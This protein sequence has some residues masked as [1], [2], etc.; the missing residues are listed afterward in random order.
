[1]QIRFLGYSDWRL[2]N[3]EELRSLILDYSTN[4]PALP[5]G[6]PFINVEAPY[7]YWSSTSTFDWFWDTTIG[8]WNTSGTME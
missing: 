8:D 4:G 3:R 6:Y 7:F 2:P 5:A 1:M